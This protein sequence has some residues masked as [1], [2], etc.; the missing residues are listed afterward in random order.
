MRADPADRHD[1]R[2]VS[3]VVPAHNEE[4]TVAAFVERTAKAFAELGRPWELVYVDD[5]STDGTADAIRAVQRSEP[6]VRLISQRRNLGLTEALNRGFREAAGEII[7]FLPA[8]LESDPAVDIPLLLGKLDEG[9]DV[10]SGWRQGRRDGKRIASRVANW[11]C[12]LLFGLDVHDMNWI[13]AFRREVTDGF[14]L[15]SSWHR[16]MLVLALNEGWRIG[17]VKVPYRPR[18][19][20]RSKFGFS[21]L[22]VSFID[23]VTLKF[24][25][26]FQRKPML[27]FGAIGSGMIGAGLLLWAYLLWR[28]LS[29]HTQYRPLMLVA[30]IA[31]L[32]GLLVVLVGFL[33]ELVVNVSERVDQLERRLQAA[34]EARSA[35]QAAAVPSSSN[36]IIH[37]RD[38]S[39]STS[40]GPAGSK[41]ASATTSTPSRTPR[42][43]GV[44]S[45]KNPT[46]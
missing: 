27:F 6:R 31:M 26:T 1:G 5:G 11:T 10:V 19:A 45:D 25:L 32:A 42:P 37:S 34:A 12:R 7:V 33:A 20:G 2:L 36:S 23:V 35:S 43:A 38:S 16:Y 46:A 17:E 8:D 9:Y 15:R 44:K 24:L 13:K 18:Q 29:S 28:F 30:G 14:A 3:V 22:P 39:A 4:A 40:A 41:G 21:R